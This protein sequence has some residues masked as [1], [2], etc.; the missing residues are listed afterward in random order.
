MRRVKG[1]WWR[2]LGDVVGVSMLMGIEKMHVCHGSVETLLLVT[3]PFATIE[4]V[5]RHVVEKVPGPLL[6]KNRCGLE[7]IDDSST[8]LLH[9]R[10]IQAAA[11]VLL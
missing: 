10:R 4:L 9:L 6:K 2:E 11:T 3:V 5:D 1:S 7:K 8:C